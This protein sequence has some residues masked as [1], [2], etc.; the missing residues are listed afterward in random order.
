M[1]D[2]YLTKPANF[3]DILAILAD[4]ETRINHHGS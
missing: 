3:D 1:R 2:M 4:T